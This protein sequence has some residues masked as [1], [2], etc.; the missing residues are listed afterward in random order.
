M[1]LLHDYFSLSCEIFLVCFSCSFCLC[2]CP[3]LLW[4]EQ[5]SSAWTKWGNKASLY[6]GSP[7]V[8]RLTPSII[9]L[10]FDQMELRCP[11]SLQKN[12]AWSCEPPISAKPTGFACGL[13][14]EPFFVSAFLCATDSSV[15][16]L[17]TPQVSWAVSS[18]PW[19][20]PGEGLRGK[21]DLADLAYIAVI[22]RKLNE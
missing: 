10:S 13:L 9:Y 4:F 3:E 8:G 2:I 11:P 20:S 15:P 7:S 1:F 21:L 19:L 5:L 16:S 6:F 12:W 17:L 18:L 14:E 22:C